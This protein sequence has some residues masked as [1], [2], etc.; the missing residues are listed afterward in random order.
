M[1]QF[2]CTVCICARVYVVR[3]FAVLQNERYQMTTLGWSKNGLLPTDRKH[4]STRNGKVGWASLE[5]ADMALI[6][7]GWT[8]TSAW[9]VDHHDP[10]AFSHS[11]TYNSPLLSTDT[12]PHSNTSEAQLQDQLHE[13]DAEGWRYA[14]NFGSMEGSSSAIKGL[15]HFVRRRRRSRQQAFVGEDTFPEDLD[16]LEADCVLL[17]L[18]SCCQG[19]LWLVGPATTVTPRPYAIWRIVCWRR[20]RRLLW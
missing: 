15:T 2:Y 7:H 19:L 12:P 13:C 10:S 16:T 9:S 8:W 3:Y 20:S 17:C 11:T 18:V 1:V 6:T 5:A 14:T 4:I